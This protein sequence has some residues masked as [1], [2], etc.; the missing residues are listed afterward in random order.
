MGY[1]LLSKLIALDFRKSTREKTETL[2][3]NDVFF[4]KSLSQTSSLI[5]LDFSDSPRFLFFNVVSSP[6][7]RQL[8]THTGG[9]E[10]TPEA[11]GSKTLPQWTLNLRVYAHTCRQTKE[12]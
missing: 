4:R 12:M 2:G 11:P 5:R 10:G 8:G 9:V 1:R 6:H 7:N 3:G